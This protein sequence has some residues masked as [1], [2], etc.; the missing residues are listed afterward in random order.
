MKNDLRVDLLWAVLT[1]FIAGGA[2]EC[3]THEFTDDIY[4]CSIVMWIGFLLGIISAI[5]DYRKKNGK[6][7][8]SKT[9]D[10]CSGTLVKEDDCPYC[11]GSGRR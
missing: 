4:I 1:P 8:A 2:F 11:K 5:Y 7:T 9:N 3:L 6:P 10:E